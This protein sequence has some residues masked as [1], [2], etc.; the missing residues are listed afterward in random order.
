M[1]ASA[2]GP[3][4]GR[5][6]RRG[7][8]PRGMSVGIVPRMKAG[9]M[10]LAALVPSLLFSRAALGEHAHEPPFPA[11]KRSVHGGYG[12]AG[13][14]FYVC[15]DVVDA[16]VAFRRPEQ[17]TTL[18]KYGKKRAAPAYGPYRYPSR[19]RRDDWYS[20]RDYPYE[21]LDGEQYNRDGYVPTP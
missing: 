5:R 8:L 11:E 3:S 15:A 21:R 17:A 18:C 12:V 7:S 1:S 13:I 14:A 16:G 4:D 9:R 2:R 6:C 10:L 19:H 20:N